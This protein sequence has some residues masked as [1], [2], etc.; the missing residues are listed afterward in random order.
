M[1]LIPGFFDIFLLN[2]AYDVGVGFQGI[3]GL[4]FSNL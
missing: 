4:S 3:T 1:F 2:G